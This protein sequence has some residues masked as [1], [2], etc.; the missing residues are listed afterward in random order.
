MRVV[1]INLLHRTD[2]WKAVQPE[3]RKLGVTPLK[4]MGIYGA[5][6]TKRERGRNGCTRS[7]L[8]CM[9]MLK[10]DVVLMI[11]ED[12]ILCCVDNPKEVIE[13]AFYDLPPEWDALYLGAN[14]TKPIE[15]YSPSLFRLKGGLTTHAIIWNNKDGVIDEILANPNKELAFDDWMAEIQERR[16]IFITYPMVL[17]Q[18]QWDSDIAHRTDA[19]AILRNYKRFTV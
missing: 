7:H 14:L 12:D 2:K 19:S 8:A 17:T 5:G 3:F 11:L 18:R 13:N 4:F 10:D 6:M 15:R 1:C 16:N 9:E